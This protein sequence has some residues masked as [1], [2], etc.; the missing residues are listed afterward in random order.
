MKLANLRDDHRSLT[1]TNRFARPFCRD[2][3]AVG[4]ACG[5]KQKRRGKIPRR[6][7]SLSEESSD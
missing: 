5:A 2:L 4:N 7:Q 1:L 3:F 6:L